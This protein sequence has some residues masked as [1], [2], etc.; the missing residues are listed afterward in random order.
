MANQPTPGSDPDP[1]PSPKMTVMAFYQFQR[2]DDLPLLKA[3]LLKALQQFQMKGTILVA[4][5]G[6]NGTIAGPSPC[7][8]QMLG[9]LRAIPGLGDLAPKRSYCDEYP[10]LRSKVKIKQEIVTMGQP[11]L[12]PNQPG[13][14]V[15]PQDWNALISD[16]DVVLVDTRNDY[17][18]DIGTFTGAI[19]PNTTRFRDFPAFVEE[20]LD[21]AQHKKVAMFCTGGIRC[22][23]STAYLKSKGFESVY[24]LQ[25]GILQYLEDIRPEDSLWQGDCFVFDERVAVDHTLEP[26]GYIQCHACRRP[27]TSA[28]TNHPNYVRGESCHHCFA[29][30]SAADKARFRERQRQIDLAKA[31]GED[32]LGDGAKATHA[33][34]RLAK[35][36]APS[37]TPAEP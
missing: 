1:T 20:T 6:I 36:S 9:M 16:P 5:E 27:L 25:G 12:D 3:E 21:P 2:F 19:N 24:H 7:A 17:E 28:D 30:K 32:H 34:R 11:D 37:S 33:E 35:R 18:V 14:Y 23:K 4:H 10:F 22:E 26:A 31:R 13:E 29:E 15:S 8:E